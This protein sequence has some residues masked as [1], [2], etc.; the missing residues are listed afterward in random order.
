MLH[1]GGLGQAV[2]MVALRAAGR[3]RRNPVTFI[4][5]SEGLFTEHVA[6]AGS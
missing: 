4:R 2:R 6:A 5:R 1:E 3:Y